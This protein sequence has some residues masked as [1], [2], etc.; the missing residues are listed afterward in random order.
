MKPG[1]PPDLLRHASL[2]VGRVLLRLA[3]DWRNAHS[4]RPH[5]SAQWVNG[6]RPFF[7]AALR[8]PSFPAQHASPLVGR[9]LL[10]LALDADPHE[11]IV[12][13][14]HG[15]NLV[16]DILLL[17]PSAAQAWLSMPYCLSSRWAKL[18]CRFLT[19]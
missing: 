1:L 6:A 7:F 9:A 5:A 8:L 12:Q 14:F 4:T 13:T 11:L 2:L 19:V 10:K 3:T 17:K 16:F 18:C 15:P